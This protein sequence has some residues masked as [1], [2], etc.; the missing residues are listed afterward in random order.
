MSFAINATTVKLRF[1]EF[2]YEADGDIEFAIEEANREVDPAVLGKDTNE[3]FCYL[4]AHYLMCEIQR[5]LSGTGQIISSE[6]VGDFNFT[7]EATDKA[8]RADPSDFS[9]T[10]YG[11]RFQKIVRL[12]TGGPVII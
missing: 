12:R 6:R 5:R 3:A 7:Y 1:K 9:S 10:F 2:R 11:S 4:A 8:T